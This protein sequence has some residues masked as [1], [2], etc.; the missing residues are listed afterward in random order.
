[1]S[2]T[3]MNQPPIYLP[4][5]AAIASEP[6]GRK[7]VLFYVPELDVMI[8][9][10]LAAQPDQYTYRW[11]YHPGAQMHVLLFGWPTGQGAG[12]AIPEGAGDALLN[13]LLGLTDIYVTSHPLEELQGGATPEAIDHVRLGN[14]VYLPDVKFKPEVA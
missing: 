8:K 10:V 1:M 4:T 6:D 13:Y 9:Q 7:I 2:D 11:G 3:E 5:D 14:T 12:L